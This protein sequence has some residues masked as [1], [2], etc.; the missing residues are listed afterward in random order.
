MSVS[1]ALAPAFAARFGRSLWVCEEEEGAEG[2]KE[3]RVGAQRLFCGSARGTTRGG[4]A[5]ST[6]ILYNDSRASSTTEHPST[7][8]PVLDI[9]YGVYSLSLVHLTPSV[10]GTRDLF[11]NGD[12]F[13]CF[14]WVSADADGPPSTWSGHPKPPRRPNHSRAYDFFPEGSNVVRI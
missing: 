2:N 4:R 13:R 9:F 3:E 12:F 8:I 11:G 10:I 6:T 7:T 14:L 1:A 5:P